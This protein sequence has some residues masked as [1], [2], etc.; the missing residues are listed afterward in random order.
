TG[1]Q[2]VC[3]RDTARAAVSAGIS[4]DRIR[5]VVSGVAVERAGVR[6]KALKTESFEWAR[7]WRSSPRESEPGYGAFSRISEKWTQPG[8]GV[9]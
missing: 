1:A 4:E 7:R 5:V 6:V 9:A 3:A 2:L 8:L